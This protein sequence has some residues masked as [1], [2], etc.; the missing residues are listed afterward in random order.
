MLKKSSCLRT[1]SKIL[2]QGQVHVLKTSSITI[3]PFNTNESWFFFMKIFV[4]R[5][6]TYICAYAWLVNETQCLLLSSGV[7]KAPGRGVMRSAW[8]WLFHLE[9]T[10]CRCRQL[11]GLS[12]YP[13]P[14]ATMSSTPAATSPSAWAA[15]TP[16]ARPACTNCTAR[17][18]LLTRR[19]LALTLMCCLS[20]VPSC[21]WWG[22]RW[23][24]HADMLLTWLLLMFWITMNKSS[25]AVVLGLVSMRRF[26]QLWLDLPWVFGFGTAE[27]S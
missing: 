13:A 7:F 15:R 4:C 20:T 18:V 5:F 21:S 27:L 11:N 6:H 26:N 3:N 14:S 12:F 2:E 22:C 23:V 25:V 19:P 24:G 10:G 8:A 16:S 9:V 17:P 1:H